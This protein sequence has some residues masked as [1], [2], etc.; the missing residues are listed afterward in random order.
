MDENGLI[1]EVRTYL[2]GEAIRDMFRVARLGEYIVDDRYL[3]DFSKPWKGVPDVDPPQWLIE[4]THAYEQRQKAAVSVIDIGEGDVHVIGSAT[5]DRISI[6]T[7]RGTAEL[8]RDALLE[9]ITALQTFVKGPM[10]L[11]PIASNL[12]SPASSVSQMGNQNVPGYKSQQERN[13][14]RL[15]Y[16]F[17]QERKKQD[18]IIRANQEE[19]QRRNR[20]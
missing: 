6:A 4:E 18:A 7:S 1:T 5:S 16:A 10:G 17:A 2:R 9:V 8:E 14:E 13:Q 11:P 20:W 19:Y 15:D 12:T 3:Q